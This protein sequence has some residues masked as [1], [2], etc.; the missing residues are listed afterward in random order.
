MF[1]LYYARNDGRGFGWTV[2]YSLNA[3]CVYHAHSK[4]DA[5]RHAEKM[6]KGMVK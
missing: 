5:L 6:N 2:R 1:G 4:R 3:I